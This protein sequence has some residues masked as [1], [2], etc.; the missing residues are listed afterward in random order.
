MGPPKNNTAFYSTQMIYY[1]TIV[2][3]WIHKNN[4]QELSF[5][6]VLSS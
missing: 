3:N 5:L 1:I 6:R 2:E 4:I